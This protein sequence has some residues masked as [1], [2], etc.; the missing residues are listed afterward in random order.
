MKR[1][2]AALLLTVVPASSVAQHTPGSNAGPGAPRDPERRLVPAWGYHAYTNEDFAWKPRDHGRCTG[3]DGAGRVFCGVK[4]GAVL[5][6]SALNGG[7]V[8]S[9]RTKASVRTAPEVTREGVFVGSS[10]GCVYRLDGATGRPL[11]KKPFCADAAVW[12]GPVVEGGLVYFT[13][14]INKLY[15]VSAEDGSFRWEYHRDRPQFM[16]AEGVASPTVAGDRVLVGF[17]DGY[18]VSVDRTTGAV[19]W[20]VDLSQGKAQTDVDTTPLVEGDR[21]YAASFG[22]GPSAV[23]LADGGTIWH[24]KWFGATRPAVAD[25]LLVFGTSDGEV[26]GAR[27]SDGRTVFVTKLSH[28]AAWQPVVLDGM[29]VVGGDWGLVS[30]SLPSGAPMELLQIPFGTATTP[31]AIGNRLFLVGGGGSV[32]AVDVKPR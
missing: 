32:D 2:L 18:L 13:V 7:L 21:V 22:E 23:R 11:W 6:L 26:V 29:A 16:S 5:A 14:T 27:K 19:A 24:G 12:G 28:S 4:S 31:A 1:L 8:W 9:Y 25:D 10:D 17:S 20:Q 30:L 15:A 3:D